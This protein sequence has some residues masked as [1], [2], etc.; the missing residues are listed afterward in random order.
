VP[1]NLSKVKDAF[2]NQV[3][4]E[5]KI[6]STNKGGFEVDLHG[7][8]SFCPYSQ[9]QLGYCDKPEE[10]VGQKMPFMVVTFERGGRNIVVSRRKL[11]E[12]EGKAAAGDT[13][14]KLELG[15]EFEGAVRR[16]QPYGAFIDIGGMDGLV[17][18]SEISHGRISNPSDVL[19]VG[20]KVSV[21]VIKLEGEGDKRRISLSMKQLGGDPWA[22]VPE[23][24]AEGATV[25][26]KVV[27]LAEFGAF[28]EL[29]SGVD[30]LVHISEISTERIQHPSDKLQKGQDVEVRVL[31][32][33]PD[34]RRISLT[35][36]SQEEAEQA[37][38]SRPSHRPAGG[39]GGGGYGGGGG[40]GGR[41]RRDAGPMHHRSE[42]PEAEKKPKQDLTKMPFEDALQ[43]LK[44]KFKG[45]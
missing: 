35:M 22:E 12:E 39:G 32:V 20:D 30:G 7:V 33:D 40:G 15:A 31:Q 43:A 4:M 28:I 13:L 11:L 27:R 29:E 8:R 36:L 24:Y 45:D 3:P 41:G 16:L 25:K 44:N 42:T 23:K 19:K 34:Q 5:G 6:K 21:K 26:G 38:A 17:H 18:V 9:I 2:E 14:E 1:A 37:R 10:Y